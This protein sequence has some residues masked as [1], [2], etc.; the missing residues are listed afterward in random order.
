MRGM[1]MIAILF[2]LLY[3]ALSAANIAGLR[4]EGDVSRLHRRTKP[5]LCPVLLAAYLCTASAAGASVIWL[6]PAGLLGGFLGDT[7]L[8]NA[9]RYFLP[10]LSSFLLGHLC[11]TAAFLMQIAALGTGIPV[12]VILP[13]LAGYILYILLAARPVL[14]AAKRELRI[15]CSLYMAVIFLMS[16]SS[17]LMTATCG[18]RFLP[19]FLGSL[20]FIISDTLLSCQIVLRRSGR[21]VME[22]YLPAQALI[23]LGM[24]LGNLPPTAIFWAF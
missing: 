5:L 17:L 11:Y 15:G 9:E 14:R 10:G 18:M 24:I 20:F 2:W 19:T 12:S 22:T 4:R 3:L 7:F 13:G 8:L 16:F 23:A 1:T 21:G 6:I